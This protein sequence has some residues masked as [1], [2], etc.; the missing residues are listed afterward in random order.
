M[1]QI[2]QRRVAAVL[3]QGR[4]VLVVGDLNIAVALQDHCDY[5]DAR[6]SV[7]ATFLDGRPDRKHLRG[8]LQE[9]GGPLT[10]LFR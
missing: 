3:A 5:A 2:L 10:D 9:G 1:L 6:P 8:L 7:Q 4:A